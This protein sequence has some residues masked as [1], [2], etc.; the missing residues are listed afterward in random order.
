MSNSLTQVTVTVIDGAGHVSTSARLYGEKP[1]E[2]HVADRIDE[3]RRST[4][5]L[6]LPFTIHVSVQT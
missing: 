1:V 5:A 6:L 3:V 2:Q 4:G